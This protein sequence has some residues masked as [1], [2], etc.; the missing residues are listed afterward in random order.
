MTILFYRVKNAGSGETRMETQNDFIPTSFV[1]RFAPLIAR[2]ASGLPIADVACGSGRNTTV[3]LELGCKVICLDKDL[4]QLRSQYSAQSFPKD[5]E[6]VQI[7]FHHQP[8]P[9][10][11]N[12][13]GA[14]INVHFL[15]PK[16]FPFFIKSLIPGG[17]LLIQTVPGCGGNYLQLPK[18]NELRSTLSEHFEFE[19]YQERPVGPTA[20]NSVTV[21]L[22]AKRRP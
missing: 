7:D 3:F 17:Y 4:G 9:S 10:V 6:A 15:L 14:I 11:T 2:S 16:L 19:F 13:V 21:N 22:L 18:S 20:F 12:K 8:W 1:K 5:I